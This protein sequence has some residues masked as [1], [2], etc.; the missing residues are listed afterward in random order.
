M[1][2]GFPFYVLIDHQYVHRP[3]DLPVNPDL[4][5]HVTTY[6]R[7]RMNRRHLSRVV[8]A[9]EHRFIKLMGQDW[10]YLAQSIHRAIYGFLYEAQQRLVRLQGWDITKTEIKFNNPT[11]QRNYERRLEQIRQNNALRAPIPSS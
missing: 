5:L 9:A 2:E 6:L 3:R 8:Y 4:E 10:N 7:E 1:R 11:L